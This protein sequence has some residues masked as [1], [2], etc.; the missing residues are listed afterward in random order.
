MAQVGRRRSAYATLAGSTAVTL[1]AALQSLV[2][3]PLYLNAVGPRLYGA[4]L[5]TG[6]MTVWM[7]AFDFGIPN[8][9]VQRTGAFLAEGKMREIGAHLGASLVALGCIALL[10]YAVIWLVAPAVGPWVGVQGAEA[11][12]LADAMRLCG[13]AVAA[14]LLGFGVVGL[15]RGLQDTVMVQGF[16]LAGVVAG[17]AVTAALLATG[18]GL[19]A[20]AIG[21][22]LRA[23][24]TLLGAV[25]FLV[26][27][28][29]REIVSSLRPT[30]AAM[31]DIGKHCPPLFAAG[32]GYALMN[33]S[34]VTI[35]AVT[36]GP[37]AAAVL[38]VT[39]KVADLVRGVLDMIG[40]ASY[41]GFA[42]LF[43]EG[44]APRTRTV[45][46]ELESTYFVAALS[47]L[48]AYVAANATLVANWVG[49]V[50]YGGFALTLALAF[51]A[52]T[53]GWS[54]MQI[55]L[56]RSTGR[57]QAASAAL[58]LECGA[59]LA[60]MFGLARALGPVGLPI[61]AVVTALAS[62]A[63][64]SRWLRKML[65]CDDQRARELKVWVWRALPLALAVGIGLWGALGGWLVAVVSGFL[66]CALAITVLF[67]TDPAL[68]VRRRAFTSRFLRGAA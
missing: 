60:L 50:M 27:R 31:T 14:T 25:A 65:E 36:F 11:Q 3:L 44:D 40:H 29:D 35:A 17:F 56:L 57:H 23:C 48:S 53:G 16:T 68:A 52:G 41:G 7:L 22:V 39:R 54:Y 34:M 47:L 64:A 45:Y 6:E 15:S 46:G 51:A 5:A 42:H 61:G 43:A 19:V 30:R 21:L 2:L 55:S 66:V 4:W 18:H 58:L 12:S 33:N 10:M 1:V 26:L 49:T 67:L 20:I 28:T 59:R 9:L 13:V 8:L 38:G 32:I 37:V 24:V 62:G 63:W